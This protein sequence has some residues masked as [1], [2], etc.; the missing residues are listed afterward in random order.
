LEILR[1]WKL[2]ENLSSDICAENDGDDK[3]YACIRRGKIT[4]I[5]LENGI[6]KQY[7]IFDFSMWNIISYGSEIYVGC[8]NGELIEL[9]KNNMSIKKRKQIHIKNIYSFLIQKDIIYTASQDSSLIATD[10]KHLE[11]ILMVK[12]AI[13]NML[14][15]LG[16]YETKLI[17]VRANYI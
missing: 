7:P 9:N 8:V 2:G 13:F 1:T 11:T 17:K 12:K 14:K 16:I 6:F 10:L 4:V 3:V 15:I 5:D